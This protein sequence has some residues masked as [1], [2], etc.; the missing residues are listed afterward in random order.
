MAT[1]K[2][3][4]SACGANIT[5]IARGSKFRLLVKHFEIFKF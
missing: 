5:D 4:K 1:K 2:R 3:W